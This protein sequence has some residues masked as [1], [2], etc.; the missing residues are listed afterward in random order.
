MS[1]GRGATTSVIV[2]DNIYV[3]NGYQQNGGNAN[4]IEKYNITDNKWSV[5]NATLSPKN[6]RIRR[7]T[8]IRFIFLTAGKQSS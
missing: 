1:A 4:F 7:R 6:L 2:D 5:L 3:S 8:I